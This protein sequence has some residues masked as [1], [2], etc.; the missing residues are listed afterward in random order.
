MFRDFE[1]M[2]LLPR[3]RLVLTSREEGANVHELHIC[4]AGS[5]N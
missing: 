1:K 3:M 5:N 4:E 2:M